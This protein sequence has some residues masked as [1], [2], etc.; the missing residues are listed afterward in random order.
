MSGEDQQATVCFLAG[1]IGVVF[2]CLELA[3][4]SDWYIIRTIRTAELVLPQT[5][6]WSGMGVSANQLSFSNV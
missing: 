6:I 2:S 3:P 5:S 4:L 1:E